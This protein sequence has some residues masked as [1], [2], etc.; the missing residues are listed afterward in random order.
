[1]TEA[2]NTYDMA[3]LSILLGRINKSIT[4]K[5]EEEIMEVMDEAW[6]EMTE[7]ERQETNDK[8]KEILEKHGLLDAV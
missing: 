3:M 6:W 2:K 8:C 7:E 5:K 1:M 4:D